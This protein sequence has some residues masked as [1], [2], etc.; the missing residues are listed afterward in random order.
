VESEVGYV[1]IKMWPRQPFGAQV[2]LNGH[3]LFAAQAAQ[4]GVDYTKEGSCITAA[5]DPAVGSDRKH[6]IPDRK[7]L[8][9]DR[10]HLIRSA[11]SIAETDGHARARPPSA[12]RARPETDRV[13]KQNPLRSN[14]SIATLTNDWIRRY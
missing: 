9:P 4:A 8:I 10:K 5:P 14:R 13:D 3:E 7:H 12:I 1:T 2:I 6:L 11:P